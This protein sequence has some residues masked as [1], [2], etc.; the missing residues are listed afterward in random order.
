MAYRSYSLKFTDSDF[1]MI[2]DYFIVSYDDVRIDFQ[3]KVW[4]GR[5]EEVYRNVDGKWTVEYKK[6][7]ETY[8]VNDNPWSGHAKSAYTTWHVKKAG[9]QQKNK[10][11]YVPYGQQ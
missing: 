1:A 2:P 9:T 6:D 11:L 3:G 8:F 10:E 5:F 4:A 7:G